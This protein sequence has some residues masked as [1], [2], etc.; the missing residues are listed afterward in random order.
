MLGQLVDGHQFEQ[1]VSKDALPAVG[2]DTSSRRGNDAL[3]GVEEE[4]LSG[5]DV[6][7]QNGRNFFTGSQIILS[8][9]PD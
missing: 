6:V 5:I 4:F 8:E 2:D 7:D 3:E 9:R 1:D